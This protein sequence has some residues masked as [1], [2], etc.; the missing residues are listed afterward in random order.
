MPFGLMNVGATFQRAMD[1][2]FAKEIH[3]FIVV[4]QD[5]ITVFSKFDNEH[6]DHLRKVFIKCRKFG[7]SLNPK[8][9][10]F[11]LEEGKLLGHIIYKDGNRI[12]PARIEAIFT[13]SIPRTI[14]ELQSFLGK[15]NFLRR[16]ISNLEKLIRKLN[17]MLRQDLAIKW[18]VEAKQ[19]F[20][21]IKEALTKTPVL[22]SLD[23]N[24]DFIIFSFALE[25]TIVVVLLQ[26]NNQGYEQLIA[27]FS[28]S[29]RDAT[30]K[31]N[32]MEKQAL[33][34]VKAIKDFRVYIL[35]S[36]IIDY[37]PNSV[38]RDI[39]TQNGPEG[40][41]GKWIATILEYDI[42]IKP[43]KLIKGQGLAKIM[44][45]LNC[46]ALDIN[47][48]SALDD[49]EEMATPQINEPFTDSPWYVDITFV[50]LNL[51]A[52]PGL[53]RTEA[54]FLKIKSLRYC[55][56]DNALFWKDNS[57][58]L[59]TCLLKDEAD[60]ILQEFHAGDRGGHLY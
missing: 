49:Q 42:E 8:K 55:I 21:A 5:E 17:S 3:D 56:V 12:D 59:L 20:E 22:I 29:L 26:K 34:L 2:A 36:H 27:F 25:H 54:R 33:A 51:Q 43:T 38:V 44:A 19:S 31:Y 52:P 32:I 48:I 53:T 37:V 57:S 14:K 28:K 7:I 6:L 45:E 41:R 23:F 15:I 18:I 47:F 24:K 9:A 39:L 46:Q 50:L 11:G 1:I 40:Q 10:L 60:R 35:Y 30:L 13:I 58:I 16:F 4:Y